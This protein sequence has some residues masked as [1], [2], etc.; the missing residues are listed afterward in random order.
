MDRTRLEV[1]VFLAAAAAAHRR[2][3]A[4]VE[5]LVRPLPD[6]HRCGSM[7]DWYRLT[8][9]VTEDDWV[10]IEALLCTSAEGVLI[11]LRSLRARAGGE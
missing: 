2:D 4:T 6:P 8:Q 10:V 5:R 9:P 7:M 1:D 11:A 3:W